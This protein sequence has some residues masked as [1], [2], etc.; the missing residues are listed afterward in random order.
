MADVDTVHELMDKQS[1]DTKLYA[2]GIVDPNPAAEVKSSESSHNENSKH[3]RREKGMNSEKEQLNS[4]VQEAPVDYEHSSFA[5]A[6]DMDVDDDDIT[7]KL[8]SIQVLPRIPKRKPINDERTS[9]SLGETTSYYGVLDH[10]NSVSS[11]SAVRYP[12]WSAA[13]W[14]RSN[15]DRPPKQ[16][17]RYVSTKKVESKTIKLIQTEKQHRNDTELKTKVAE[18]KTKSAKEHSAWSPGATDVSDG[19]RFSELES[20]PANEDTPSALTGPLPTLPFEEQMRE[21]ARLRNLKKRG[22]SDFAN[23]SLNSTDLAPKNSDSS[24]DCSDPSTVPSFFSQTV[25]TGK[26]VSS[27]KQEVNVSYG[28]TSKLSHAKVVECNQRSSHRHPSENGHA[29]KS[30]KSNHQTSETAADGRAK[31]SH[32][33]GKT[34]ATKSQSVSVD[35]A[36]KSK[37][38]S[39]SPPLP[40]LPVLPLFAASVSEANDSAVHR[41][42]LKTVSS[43][44]KT[45]SVLSTGQSASNHVETGGNHGTDVSELKLPTSALTVPGAKSVKFSSSTKLE[46]VSE[47]KKKSKSKVCHR[48]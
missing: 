9:T 15:I 27:L 47:T 48:I 24:K 37:T 20:I 30:R 21:R 46:E 10:V 3:F 36:T 2:E 39:G 1:V 13:G 8:L 26:P 11:S 12:N 19:L 25:D 38:G 32:F 41:V 35:P 6:D 5:D 23:A 45:A 43:R 22:G 42:D 18:N 33:G 31:V 34:D 4:P 28:G 29:H 7:R 17:S 16:W 14:S 44:R 40:H